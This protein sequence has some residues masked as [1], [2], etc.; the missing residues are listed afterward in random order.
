MKLSTHKLTYCAL[1]AA[2]T[3]ILSQI[4]IPLPF[5]PIMINL[6]L[7]SVFVSAGILGKTAGTVCQLVYV[8]LG[9]IGLPVFANFSGG[10]GVL[11]GPTGGYIIGY[12]VAAFVIGLLCDTFKNTFVNNVLFIIAG[13]ALCYTFGTAWFVISAH[14]GI[15]QALVM[16]VLPFLVGDAIKICV[17]A[18]LIKTLKNKLLKNI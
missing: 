3:A 2:L 13:L 18:F 11:A 10:I 12:I 16:C 8:G 4:A 9:V 6:A 5:T 15:A 1:F 17:A 7:L 14:V